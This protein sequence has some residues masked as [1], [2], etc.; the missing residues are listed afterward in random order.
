M[1]CSLSSQVGSK[2]YLFFWEPNLISNMRSHMRLNSWLLIIQH[3]SHG[4][5]I[6]ARRL[7][8]TKG[9]QVSVWQWPDPQSN[10]QGLLTAGISLGQSHPVPT[11]VVISKPAFSSISKYYSASV[12]HLH[13]SAVLL[14]HLAPGSHWVS[15]GPPINPLHCFIISG[16]PL[17][18]VGFSPGM[19]VQ[20]V[21]DSR[22]HN[23]LKDISLIS[24]QLEAWSTEKGTEVSFSGTHLYLL[25][26]SSTSVPPNSGT[27]HSFLSSHA[28]NV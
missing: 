28:L 8:E 24:P 10:R 13:I 21:S 4:L 26:A 7:G 18:L 11:S 9:W 2:Y 3:L 15:F 23:L 6:D 12:L 17:T 25:L 16:I 5:C 14:L 27:C 19:K 20:V 22:S 1:H